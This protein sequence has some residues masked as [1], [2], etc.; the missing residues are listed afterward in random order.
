MRSGDG[1]SGGIGE[2]GLG[3]LDIA[4][5]FTYH[6]LGDTGA[7]SALGADTG[8]R[9]YFPIT[10]AAFIDGFANL[11][12]GNTLAKTDVHKN[13]PLSLFDDGDAKQNENDCQN[14]LIE[15]SFSERSAF[16]S[17]NAGHC[18]GESLKL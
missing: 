18:D 3:R 11:T 5:G 15:W 6:L 16:T 12:V 2:S 4:Q 13:Y 7:F 9:A 8:R 10:A 17:R 14:I 1:V